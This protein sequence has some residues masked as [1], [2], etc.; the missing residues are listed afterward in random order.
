MAEDSENNCIEEIEDEHADGGKHAAA[1]ISAFDSISSS[2]REAIVQMKQRPTTMFSLKSITKNQ[3]K[4]RATSSGYQNFF[5]FGELPMHSD[6]FV[7]I[8]LNV[9]ILNECHVP[10]PPPPHILN[11]QPSWCY[12]SWSCRWR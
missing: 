2:T 12:F 11:Q 8:A 10:P 7:S 3:Q 9:G 4:W 6:G 1:A 5:E